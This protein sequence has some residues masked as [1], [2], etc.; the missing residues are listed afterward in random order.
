MPP[1]FEAVSLRLGLVS[2]T[3]MD[4]TTQQDIAE[5]SNPHVPP[6]AAG[7]KCEACVGTC[8][9]LSPMM[10]PPST[11]QNT[12]CDIDYE[13]ARQSWIERTR[14]TVPNS[15]KSEVLLYR[16]N[17]SKETAYFCYSSRDSETAQWSEPAPSGIPDSTSSKS[18]FQRFVF[19]VS[20]VHCTL[21]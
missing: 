5:L 19:C 13:G 11:K 10:G 6:C 4:A 15:K 18:L 1:G 12:G 8:Q 3:S 16:N 21:D 20:M 9:P 17:H 2:L 7:A 14:Y